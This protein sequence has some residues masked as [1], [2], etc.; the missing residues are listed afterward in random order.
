M[1]FNKKLRSAL[2]VSMMTLSTSAMSFQV[3]NIELEGANRVTFETLKSYLT[4]EKGMFLSEQ[5]SQKTI[6]ELYGTGFFTD[7]SLLKKGDDTL[8]IRVQERPS[9]ADIKVEGNE[10]IDSDVLDQAL[11]SLGIKKGRILN[12]LDLDRIV[13]DLKRRYQ[14]QGYYAVVIDVVTKALPRNRLDLEI[15]IVEGQPATIGRITFVGNEVYDDQ[16]LKSL[17]GVKESAEPGKGDAYSKPMVEAD[18]EKIRSFYMDKGFSAFKI[19]SSQVTLS[20]ELSSVF[21]TININEGPQYRLGKTTFSGNTIVE[22]SELKAEFNLKENDPFNRSELISSV[23]AMKDLLSEQGYAFADINPV[24]NIDD[25]A[26]IIDV[27]FVVEPKERVYIRHIEVEGNTRTRDYVIRR[28]F[29]QMEAAPYS[30]KNV[31][32]SQKRIERLGFFKSA[33][34]ETKRVSEDQADLIVR[35]EEQ[36]TGSFTAGIGFSQLEGASYNI[37]VSERNV[38]GTGNKLDFNIASSS[39]KKSADI[40]LTNPYFSQAGLSLGGKFY[41][42]EIDAEELEVADYS[43]NNMG[44]KVTLGYPLN[45]T[46]RIST[47]LA[48]DSQELICSSTFSFCDDFIDENGDQFDSLKL[49]LGWRHNSTNAFYFPSKGH[50]TSLNLEAVVPGT[51]STPYYKVYANESYYQPITS[52]LSLMAKAGL[53]FGDGFGDLDDL[54][55]FEKF[56]AGGIGTIRGFEPNSLGGRYDYDVDGSDRPRGGSARFTST[57][58]LNMP[59]PFIDDSSNQRISFFVDS[60]A[61]YDSLSEVDAADLRVTAGVGFSWITPVGPLT[62]SLATPISSEDTDETQNFQFTLGT[63]F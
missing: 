48:I 41:L 47:G 62:F 9:I 2:L 57:L 1:K 7:V 51:S 13:Q 39:A 53:A 14:A 6:S 37:G 55:F 16:R 24:T 56:Y 32:L 33:K 5:V 43:V 21:L 12:Q 49:T 58:A 19:E 45:E 28:E 17:M 15:N 40:G 8:V 29:R 63:G 35:I 11:E 18:F 60:G 25:V 54:P 34:I 46:D 22:K 3:S 23:S 52:K 50:D 38:V 42:S 31:R 59:V 26:H 20:N 27:N 36:P 61:L 10:L 44:A 4:V 30:L